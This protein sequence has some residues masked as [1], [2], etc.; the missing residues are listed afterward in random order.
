MWSSAKHQASV[1]CVTSA[2]LNGGKEAAV[3][4]VRISANIKA[5]DCGD[6][7]PDVAFENG[8]DLVGELLVIEI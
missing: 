8:A 5:P 3:S 6:R 4:Y 1:T 2:K 7:F